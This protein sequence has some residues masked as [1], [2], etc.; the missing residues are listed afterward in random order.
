MRNL[1]NLFA[2]A[3][4]VLCA[5]NVSAEK[6]VLLYADFENEQVFNV[7][8]LDDSNPTGELSE[9]VLKLTNPS[10]AGSIDAQMTYDFEKAFFPSVEY[11]LFIKVKGSAA[12]TMV[13]DIQNTENYWS[14]SEEKAVIEF[15]T[16]WR[17]ISVIVKSVA[18][19][20]NRL[21]LYFGE[22]AGEIY[23]SDI[24]LSV[25]DTS[26]EDAG[27]LFAVD[28]NKGNSPFVGWNSDYN[29]VDG[30]LKIT[31]STEANRYESQI[32]WDNPMGFEVM[33]EGV[34][35][36]NFKVKGSTAGA[37]DVE[38]QNINDNYQSVGE[39]GEIEFD[40][41]W[42]EVS[43]KCRCFAEGGHRLVFSYGDFV[44]DIFMDDM[45]LVVEPDWENI[46]NRISLQDV[47]FNLYEGWG[48]DAVK[49]EKVSPVWEM[50]VE[51][52]TPYGDGFVNNGAD[53]SEY[54]KLYV[55]VNPF[56][57]TPRIMLNRMIEEGQCADTQEESNLISIPSHEWCTS[58]YST[59]IGNTYIVDLQAILDDYGFVRLHA[60]K[61][62]GLT[63]ATIVE[64]IEVTRDG[65]HFA[66][67][68]AVL[69]SGSSMLFPVTMQ[70]EVGIT[71]FQCDVYL[72]EGISL[73]QNN[74]GKYD[75]TLDEERM[76]DHSVTSSLQ[77]DGAIRIVVASLT[78][79]EF[80]GN[81]GNLFYLN[82]TSS[83]E[84]D[85][86]LPIAVR[87]I[88]ISDSEGT[89]Y[90]LKDA[91]VEIDVVCCALGD[92]NNDGLVAIDDVVLT[93]NYVLGNTPDDFL[94]MA[95]DMN[96]DGSILIDD[97]VMVI[98]AVLG[99]DAANVQTARSMVRETVKMNGTQDGFG[100]N[101]S[102]AANYVAM[103]YDMMLPEGVG[104]DDIRMNAASNH[105]V[106]Y[107]EMEDGLVRV[108]V[109]S[110]TNEAFGANDLLDVA[111]DADENVN[112][113]IVNAYVVTRNG[114]LVEVADAEA[115]LSR[116][117]TTGILSVG[118]NAIPADIYDLSGRIVKKNATSAQ[119]L[120]KGVYLMNGKKVIVK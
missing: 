77:P 33:A 55:T 52:N 21:C 54:S 30:V 28:F 6:K 46:S 24:E 43:V 47:K 23:I 92:V 59:Q 38:I 16:E 98:N 32:A 81:N 74:K 49:G 45:E 82:L 109:A 93:I 67:N 72:P 56:A 71:A 115:I 66:M 84:E 86:T 89:R 17:D 69:R 26:V 22:F 117:G 116:G 8:G 75:I 4:L 119:G 97:V 57:E 40:T 37:M 14:T 53:L 70:N 25:D 76:D 65:N 63:S 91:T 3:L 42:R 41:E 80:W 114:L 90:D 113:S 120:Q 58:K 18:A 108:V 5:M 111:I 62:P 85:A 104:I 102:N 99:I 118:A 51:S 19:G 96:G 64:S 61:G 10:A 27:L 35:V 107:R 15:D 7:F 78:N 112:I 110:L 1:R 88:R 2:L 36:L 101:L 50:G 9:G 13:V 106:T 79:T 39:F 31:N 68:D 29:V 94:F 95:A 48:I 12:G 100:L 83:L 73:Q 87:N 105:T 60:V 11:T 103:Q 20:G 44:G 34:Y